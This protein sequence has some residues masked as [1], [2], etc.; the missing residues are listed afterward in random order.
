MTNF[1]KLT[2][3]LA[4]TKSTTVLLNVAN[5]KSVKI[6]DKGVDTHVCMTDGKFY[7]VKENVEQIWDKL[8]G[9]KYY[10]MG[11]ESKT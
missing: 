11:S 1:I 9:L 6:S 8:E 3:S 10:A 4:N 7:F 5:I 2:E